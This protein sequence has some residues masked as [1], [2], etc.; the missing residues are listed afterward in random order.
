MFIYWKYNLDEE[1]TP[2]CCGG[3]IPEEYISQYGE[4]ADDWNDASES[5]NQI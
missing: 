1:G 4:Y 2:H 3:P 5:I